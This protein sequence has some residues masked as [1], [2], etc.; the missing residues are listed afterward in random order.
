LRWQK[1]GSFG[2]LSVGLC[3]GKNQMCHFAGGLFYPMSV[4]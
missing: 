4:R 2:F 3:I 1:N